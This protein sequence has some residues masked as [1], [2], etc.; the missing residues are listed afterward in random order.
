MVKEKIF[1]AKFKE[2]ITQVLI[3]GQPDSKLFLVSNIS[4]D[5]RLIK[6]YGLEGQFQRGHIIHFTNKGNIKVLASY[7]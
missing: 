4:Y 5:R 2:N 3:I 7:Q 6:V 1:N